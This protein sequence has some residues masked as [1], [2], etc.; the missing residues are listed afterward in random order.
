ML[1]C[2]SQ[3]GFIKGRSCL[4]NLLCFIEDLTKQIDSGS[5]VDVIF[6]E[7]QKVLY[8]DHHQSLLLELK[9]VMVVLLHKMVNWI[10]NWLLGRS[11]RALV[12]LIVSDWQP[13]LSGVP[14]GSVLG[15]LLHINY[16]ND[17]IA[18]NK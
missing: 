1:I 7:F 14:R 13:V 4:T 6:F 17:N 8:K 10:E 18:S 16:L 15:P 5:P 2:E 9:K 12:E 11:Q 3:H